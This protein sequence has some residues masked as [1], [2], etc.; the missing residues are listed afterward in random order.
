MPRLVACLLALLGLAA[1]KP[2][3][4]GWLEVD[5][6]ELVDRRELSHSGESVG[7]LLRQLGGRA[8]GTRESNPADYLAHSLLE[9]LVEPYAFVLADAADTLAPLP[10]PPRVEVGALWL[11]GAP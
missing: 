6:G 2:P 9:P 7:A 8:P 4:S 10:D 11:P 1:A 5:Y 3:A